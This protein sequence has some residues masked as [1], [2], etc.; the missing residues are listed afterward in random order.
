MEKRFQWACPER[1]GTGWTKVRVGEN[2][3]DIAR[4]VGASPLALLTLNPM[5]DPSELVEGQPL[6]IPSWPRRVTL[7]EAQADAKR[8]PGQRRGSVEAVP[9]HGPCF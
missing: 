9:R 1:P 3:T 6:W 8:L 4:R 5:A 2:L 7:A